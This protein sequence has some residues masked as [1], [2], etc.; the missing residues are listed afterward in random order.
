MRFK[1]DENLPAG[2]AEL[3]T[4]EAHDAVTV[5]QQGMR[6]SQDAKLAQICQTENRVLVTLDID[7]ADIRRY[8]PRTMPGVIVLRLR[9]HDKDNILRTMRRTLPLLGQEPL[10]QKLWIVDETQV[11]IRGSED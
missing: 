6:G 3:L 7:F 4:A 10:E 11:R 2:V 8:P 1:V 9:S 5:V